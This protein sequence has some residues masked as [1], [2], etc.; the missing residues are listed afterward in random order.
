MTRAGRVVLYAP[1]LYEMQFKQHHV[2]GEA[3]ALY[4]C[5]RG[6]GYECWY[7]DAYCR[8]L[9]TP[10]PAQAIMAGQ[11]DALL[12]HLWT[13]DAYGPRLRVIADELAA[14]RRDC[15]VPVL[16]FGPLAVSAAAE[17][18]GHGA[19]DAVIRAGH[20]PQLAAGP[21]GIAA[22]VGR[23]L[24]GHVPLTALGRADL[25]YPA[26]A[27]VSVS[28]SR[29]CRG[30]CTFC[31]YNADLGGGW[32]EMPIDAIVADIAHLH[33]QTGATRFAFA[34]SDFGG[35]RPA[36]RERATHLLAGLTRHGLAGTLSLSINVRSG[37]LDAE[38]IRILA[39]AG[40]RTMLIGV[41]SLSDSTLHRIYGK[42]QD[43]AHLA[44]VIE[45]ADRC[46]ITVVAS[47]ILWH[48][49]QTLPGIRQELAAI[50]ALGR[51]RIPQF[52]ARSRLL[53]IPG[54]VMERHVR[55]SRLLD[56][57]PFQRRFRFADPGAS[58]LHDDLAAWFEREALPVISVLSED[59][60]GDL[61]TL[62]Q[63][64]IAE[65]Q[66]LTARAGLARAGTGG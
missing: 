52:M 24:S 39:D 18:A 40:V 19:V 15:G 60:P 14:V 41:E 16:A 22:A 36:C 56:E 62:A 45:A 35:T 50:E 30:R 54:T 51:H 47:Y 8:A 65:W 37:T 43:Q 28:A 21:A 44:A 61:T 66:W 11:A 55:R 63:L 34:D 26:D 38:T 5:L 9:D 49:W 33:R 7:L 53:V 3:L 46:G 20:Q 57:A 64:K 13:S 12:V 4:A 17:L 25:P 2:D 1:A 27:V 23:F 58:L 42:R 10:S 29:G 48:P 31:A 32:L 6:E 59:R